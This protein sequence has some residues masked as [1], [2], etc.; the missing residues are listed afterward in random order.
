M[1]GIT[2]ITTKIDRHFGRISLIGKSISRCCNNVPLFLNDVSDI[3]KNQRSLLLIKD[4]GE[5]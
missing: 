1:L 4:L 2:F 3:N 5:M